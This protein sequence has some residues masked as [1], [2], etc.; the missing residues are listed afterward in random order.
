[1][2]ANPPTV[3]ILGGTSGVTSN[4]PFYPRGKQLEVFPLPIKCSSSKEAQQINCLQGFVQRLQLE[5]LDDTAMQDR[6][7]QLMY[8]S[9]FCGKYYAVF[10][11]KKPGIYTAWDGEGNAAVQ[12]QIASKFNASYLE[13]STL[14]GALIFLV[15]KGL[16]CTGDNCPPYFSQEF[17]PPIPFPTHPTPSFSTA[18]PRT[19]SASPT[20][21][22]DQK[23]AKESPS[24]SPSKSKKFAKEPP[25]PS[26][27]KPAFRSTP[28]KSSQRAYAT[29]TT[30]PDFANLNF[31]SSDDTPTFPYQHIRTLSDYLGV[32]DTPVYPTPC[33]ARTFGYIID[34]YLV[35][36]G[37]TQEAITTLEH[38]V[39][40]AQGDR[41]EFMRIILPLL[42]RAEAEFI[43]E[44]MHAKVD[45]HD[46]NSSLSMGKS[47][48]IEAPKRYRSTSR[49]ILADIQRRRPIR[50]KEKRN[51]PK[52]T[53]AEKKAASEQRL[54]NRK[55]YVDARSEA[56]GVIDQE[57]A[58]LHARFG[59][60]TKEWYRQDLLQ[61]GTLAVEKRSTSRWNAFLRHTSNRLREEDP[62]KRLKVHDISASAKTEWNALSTEEKIAITDPLVAE[63]DEHKANKKFGTHNVP[64]QSFGDVNQSLQ[65]V[66]KYLIALH[67]RTGVEV[68]LIACRSSTDAYFHP[69]ATATTERAWDFPLHQFKVDASKLATLME[70]YTLTGVE[71]MVNKHT[72]TTAELK[73]QLKE[74]INTSLQETV[75]GK[76]RMMYTDFADKFTVPY[77]VVVNKW[78]LTRF[79]PPSELSRAEVDVL[80]AAWTSGTTSFVKM[81]QEEWEKWRAE[82]Q[83]KGCANNLSE[84]DGPLGEQPTHV[85]SNEEPA[86]VP[87]NN[88]NEASPT[89]ND[90]PSN[91]ASPTNNDS[92]SDVPEPATGNH[93]T[94]NGTPLEGIQPS[95]EPLAD[96]SNAIMFINSSGP[97]VKKRKK[98]ADA[99]V[100]R[101][102]RQKKDKENSST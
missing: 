89:N 93:Q 74:M 91:E 24:P 65:A 16:C 53:P 56:L 57:V 77:G 48:T 60:H 43:W 44:F 54:A 45:A 76:V 69:W 64:L 5:Q 52:K 12:L 38:A 62:T 87:S 68:L 29:N 86:N 25:S 95:A 75:G 79:C 90:S 19:R 26:P 49:K 101:G 35:S 97:A 67:A 6:I 71:G 30:M 59:G 42:P 51:R 80:Y 14:R 73:T 36:H 21:P 83:K 55:E 13:C 31:F 72:T 22:F 20:K 3:V 100:K 78:P 2:E 46:T 17:D 32:S 8:I 82:Y 28:G 63:L 11:G 47:K 7:S 23:F 18:L 85:P 34:R 81:N 1:M 33:P 98:R 10:R 27:S 41:S 92:P 102:P 50:I 96:S 61:T 37:Y 70:A 40:S 99:G 94:P 58:K 39:T 15:T 88:N 4:M 84:D 9:Q 66:E